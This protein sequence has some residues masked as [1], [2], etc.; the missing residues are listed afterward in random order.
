MNLLPQKGLGTFLTGRIFLVDNN[1]RDI[2]QLRKRIEAYNVSCFVRIV[3]FV[4]SAEIQ[5]QVRH[6]TR[7]CFVR[8][9]FF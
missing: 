5:V 9:N 3:R 7:A 2:F 6:W 4:N 1:E 8:R